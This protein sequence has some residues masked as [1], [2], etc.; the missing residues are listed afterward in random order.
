[1]AE[2]SKRAGT[3]L[4]TDLTVDDAEQVRDFYSRV[5]GW[6]SQGLDMGGYRDFNMM[7]PGETDPVAGICH[8]RGGNRDLP[9]YWLIYL[10]VENLDQSMRACREL[11]GKILIDAKTMEGYG[12]YCVIQDPAGAVAALFEPLQG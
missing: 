6:Q 11:G 10:A 5:V 8:A 3:I 7:P 1:M 12:R 4:W 9:P 2:S